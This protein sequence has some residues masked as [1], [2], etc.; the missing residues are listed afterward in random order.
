MLGGE[1]QTCFGLGSELVYL[2]LH[3][4]KLQI[5]LLALCFRR[6]SWIVVKML[7]LGIQSSPEPELITI[8][9]FTAVSVLVLPCTMLHTAYSCKSGHSNVDAVP[10]RG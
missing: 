10:G 3:N 1:V 9:A 2:E 7:S 5:Q 8:A 6:G 4:D